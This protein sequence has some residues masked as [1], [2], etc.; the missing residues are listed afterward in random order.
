[1]F[2]FMFSLSGV[3]VCI[4]LIGEAEDH[5]GKMMNELTGCPYNC[6]DKFPTAEKYRDVVKEAMDKLVKE[7][8][9]E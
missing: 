9:E 8:H 7:A 2:R 3:I 1:M 4:F 5:V 6:F